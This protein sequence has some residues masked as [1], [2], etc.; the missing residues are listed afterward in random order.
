MLKPLTMWITT[1]CVKFLEM[2]IPDYLTYLLRN[3]YAGQEQ[4]LEPDIEQ[5]AGSKLGKEYI[6]AVYCHPAYLTYMQS[7]SCEILSWINHKLDH[8]CW[9]K[10]QQLQICRWYHS[11]GRKWRG[12]KELLDEGER[13]EWQSWLETQHEKTKFM[14]PGPINSW[15]IEGG[16][17]ETVTDFIFL[18]S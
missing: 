6:E 1:N 10:C 9:E 5:W 12:S 16:K 11:N 3:L 13:G 14:A 15:Q 18:G 4:Q 2:G 17:V 8:D 7:T